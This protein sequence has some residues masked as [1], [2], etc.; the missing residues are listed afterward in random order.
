MNNMTNS[1]QGSAVNITELLWDVLSQWKVIVI[2]S[3]IMALLVPGLK[4]YVDS[5][6]YQNKLEELKQYE[7][8][9]DEDRIELI[10]S[11]L[12]ESDRLDVEYIMRAKE[13]IE[14]EKQ[15]LHGSLLLNSDPT[16]QRH[17]SIEY[18]LFSEE[19]GDMS[20]LI[21]AYSD[22]LQHKDVVEKLGE[23]ID[24]ELE[25]QYIAELIRCDIGRF[26][27]VE[28][29][30]RKVLLSFKLIVPEETDDEGVKD[31]LTEILEDYSV[32]TSKSIGKNSLTFISME[33]YKEYS[34][35]AVSNRTTIT[36]T[37]FTVQNN[38]RSMMNTVSDEAIEALELIY[39]PEEEEEEEESSAEPHFSPLYSA[40]GFV[41]GA[42][43][44]IFFYILIAILRGRISASSY[45]EN[46]T[47]S[48]TIGEVFCKGDHT[49]AGK[50]MHSPYIDRKRYKDKLDTEAQLN[51]VCSTLEAVCRH[52]DVDSV[53]LLC[54]PGLESGGSA[55]LDSIAAGANER[56][57]SAEK[58]S[59]ENN[60]DEK[61]LSN[62]KNS[63]IVAGNDSKL[64]DL[65][66][67]SML[68]RE[69]E[70]NGL[71]SIYI[72]TI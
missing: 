54:I 64:A 46:Y 43:L 22:H 45:M 15:Y 25:A 20:A 52:A 50:L 2:V 59:L 63:I 7:S 18:Q 58:L 44:Y 9:S 33:D 5:H 24:P 1:Q 37:I 65:K 57:V 41:L 61:M 4:Y 51:R 67:L 48:R 47:G 28:T 60:I 30:T 16:T 35:D 42:M 10:L 31:A 70:I 53:S 23:V 17:L 38:V 12:S 8:L 71:G 66:D 21:Y 6:V 14:E 68:C 26:S 3:L 39:P 13:W 56:G 40:V 19:P 34:A 32:Y 62:V 69:Y 11:G 55:I 27:F 29:D 36:N 72:K 49:G